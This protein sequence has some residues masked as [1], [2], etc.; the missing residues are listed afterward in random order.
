[1]GKEC[2]GVCVCVGKCV[3]RGPR[4]GGCRAWEG[5]FAG[6]QQKAWAELSLKTPGIG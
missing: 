1:M 2:I 3:L 6:L 5:R 4:G